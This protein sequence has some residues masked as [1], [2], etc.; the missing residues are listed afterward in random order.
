MAFLGFF[1]LGYFVYASL[2]AALGACSTS[3]QDMQQFQQIATIP[4]IA[5]FLL[6]FYALT[7]PDTTLATVLS[8][9]PLF[10]PFLMIVRTSVISLPLWEIALVVATSLAGIVLMTWLAAKIFRVGILMTGKK[11]TFAEIFRWLRYA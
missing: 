2:F 6:S 10:T 1:I 8:L 5:G 9:I 11:P 3:D 7:N 4:A